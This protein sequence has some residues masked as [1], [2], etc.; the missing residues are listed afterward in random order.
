MTIEAP[1]FFIPG[2][3]ASKAASMFDEIIEDNK[4]IGTNPTGEKLFRLDFKHDGEEFIA[5][6]GKPHPYSPNF[7][8]SMVRLIVEQRTPRLYKVEAIPNSFLVGHPD[9]LSRTKFVD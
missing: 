2:V 9:T 3:D 7:P 6:V 5:E 4:R 1:K 8:G